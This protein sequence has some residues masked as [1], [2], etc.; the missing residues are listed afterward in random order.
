MIPS[1]KK[2]HL[3]KESFGEEIKEKARQKVTEMI[4][5]LKSKVDEDDEDESAMI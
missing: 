4:S 3:I 5:I 2:C 1:N